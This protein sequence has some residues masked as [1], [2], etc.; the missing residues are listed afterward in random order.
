MVNVVACVGSGG[1]RV[2]GCA[3]VGL[4]CV[5][6]SFQFSSFLQVLVVSSLFV[7]F[8]LFLFTSVPVAVVVVAVVVGSSVMVVTM[9]QIVPDISDNTQTSSKQ[10]SKHEDEGLI[11]RYDSFGRGRRE[12]GR[13]VHIPSDIGVK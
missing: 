4:L 8:F 6:L 11:E 10:R 2:G 12:R 3:G 13:E 7:F 5:F 9:S 1:T